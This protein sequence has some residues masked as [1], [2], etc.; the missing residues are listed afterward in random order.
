MTETTE[1]LSIRIS[2]TCKPDH[3]LWNNNGTY[4]LDYTVHYGRMKARRRPSLHT[5]DLNEAIRLRDR[6]LGLTET[7]DAA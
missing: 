6:Q 3:H 4:Y 2:P 7:S 1:K 5:H